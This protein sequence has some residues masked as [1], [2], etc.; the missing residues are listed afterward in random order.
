MSNKIVRVIA[1]NITRLEPV[2]SRLFTNRVESDNHDC[3]MRAMGKIKILWHKRQSASATNL[4][5]AR[6]CT[7]I[8]FRHDILPG[9]MKFW[10]SYESHSHAT[11]ELRDCSR[12]CP[13]MPNTEF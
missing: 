2:Q 4:G 1:H 11:F 8:V 12:L 13:I 5:G 7:N 6:L 10:K 9:W 3:L